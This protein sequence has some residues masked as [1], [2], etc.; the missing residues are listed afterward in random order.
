M[1]YYKKNL[2]QFRKVTVHAI[3]CKVS[4]LTVYI[5]AYITPISGITF[6]LIFRDLE[7]PLRYIF[8]TTPGGELINGL[9]L[10]QHIRAKIRVKSEKTYFY[11]HLASLPTFSYY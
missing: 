2:L 11:L 10:G 9:L 4:L 8:D 5:N 1:R 3:K 7:H 6:T